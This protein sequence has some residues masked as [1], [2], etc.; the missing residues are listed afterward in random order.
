MSVQISGFT[1]TTTSPFQ[2]DSGTNYYAGLSGSTPGPYYYNLGNLYIFQD[3]NINN[4]AIGSITIP[5]NYNATVKYYLVGGGGGGGSGNGGGNGGGGGGIY[6][7]NQFSISGTNTIVLS[8]GAGG[9][10]SIFGGNSGNPGGNTELIYLG[11][12]IYASGGFAGTVTSPI[13][14]VGSQFIDSLGNIYY[15][16]GG[17]GGN[18]GGPSGGPE[19]GGNGGNGYNNIGGIGITTGGSNGGGGGGGGGTTSVGSNGTGSGGGNGGNPNGGAGGTSG[20]GGAGGIGGGGGGGTNGANGSAGGG[21][22]G[23]AGGIGGGG[24]GGG[25]GIAGGVGGPGGPGGVGGGGGSS[26]TNPNPGAGGGAGGINGGGGGAFINVGSGGNGGVGLIVLEITLIPIPISN[27]CF[28][29]NTPISTDQGKIPI[30]KIDAS[31]HT[32]NNKPITAI[33]KTITEDEYLVCFKKHSLSLNVP[34]RNTIMSKSHKVYY[35]G[36]WREAQDFIDEFEYIHEV[37]YNGETLYNILLEKHDKV[38]VNNLVCETLHPKNNIAKLYTNNFNEDYKNTIIVMMNDSILSNDFQLYNKVI[39][40][41]TENDTDDEAVY[42]DSYTIEKFEQK[43]SPLKSG[44]T[45][46]I[47]LDNTTI[48]NKLNTYIKSQKYIENNEE[49]ERNGNK[50]NMVFKTTHNMIIHNKLDKYIK[51]QKNKETEEEGII[52]KKAFLNKTRE[53]KERKEEID[54]L[55]REIRNMFRNTEIVK[56]KT[57]K[58]KMHKNNF[59]KRVYV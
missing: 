13:T 52:K 6:L 28:L 26:G 55:K 34:S 5:S 38:H 27:I 47:I 31:I 51:S 22:A 8:I 18:S 49:T 25:G 24:G 4:T 29:G 45:I 44:K 48:Q 17:G 11:N 32:I 15:Y 10:G 43:H 21:G 37:P 57:Y 58:S 46:N 1:Q 56:S 12:T 23:G 33:T 54:K 20:A 30:E 19:Q 16:G 40:L 53:E 59:T 39:E 3:F 35:K 7:S 14:G 50:L 2:N 36:I 42:E 9:A 41:L